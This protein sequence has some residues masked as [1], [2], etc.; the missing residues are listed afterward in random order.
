MKVRVIRGND[1]TPQHQAIWRRAQ[2]AEDGLASPYFCPEF[3]RLTAMVRRDVHVG[4]LEQDGCVVGFFPFQRSRR[5][6]G[7]PVGGPLSDYQG[8]IVE[9]GESWDPVELVRQCG[10]RAWEFDHLIV[11][12]R[13][14][15]P[16]HTKRMLSWVM[17][18]TG[19]FDAYCRQRQEA[20]SKQMSTVARKRRKLER[21]IGPVRYEAHSTDKRVLRTLMAW[22]SRQCIRTRNIDVFAF[23]WTVDLIDRIH[24]TQTPG[25]GGMLSAVYAGDQLVAAHMGMR[26]DRALHW[27]FPSYDE[28]FSRYSPGLILLMA[29]ARD[30]VSKGLDLIDLGKGDDFYKRHFCNAAVPIAEGRVVLPSVQSNIQKLGERT[31]SWVRRT[32]LVVPGRFPA[33]IVRRYQRWLRFR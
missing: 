11:A 18:L 31:A 17:D 30:A 28:R 14:L 5:R 7:R 8:L 13:V 24:A 33:R 27:W 10:L 2:K 23:K 6:V 3:T 22:K 26:S 20:G 29:I 15:Q 16:Y 12:Q 4:V 21:E 9:Q 19:G 25:F 1:L 32:P